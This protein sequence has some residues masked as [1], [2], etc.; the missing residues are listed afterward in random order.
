MAS[1]QGECPLQTK[2][3]GES[4]TLMLLIEGGALFENAALVACR[5][6]SGFEKGSSD[7]D[8]QSERLRGSLSRDRLSREVGSFAS[9]KV[10]PL[11]E[12]QSPFHSSTRPLRAKQSV[13]ATQG[14]FLKTPEEQIFRC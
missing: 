4:A 8:Q 12:G 9:T 3:G 11:I 7:E 10:E 6:Q 5:C 14:R 13:A 2:P 1:D